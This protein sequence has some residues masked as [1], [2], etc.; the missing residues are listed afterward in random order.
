MKDNSFRTRKCWRCGKEFIVRDYNEWVFRRE[1]RRFDRL[2]C[3]WSCVKAYDR[4]KEGKR[5]QREKIIEALK[6]GLSV[7]E[8]ANMLD[9]DRS[10]VV[11]WAKKL[12][13]EKDHERSV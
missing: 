1:V 13:E 12:E 7:N 11:Y 8:V 2:F 6:D 3:S 5:D 4:E 10:K 9:A